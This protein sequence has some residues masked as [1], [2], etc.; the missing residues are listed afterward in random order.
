MASKVLSVIST[1]IMSNHICLH[2]FS[3]GNQQYASTSI[4]HLPVIWMHSLRPFCFSF[5]C[6]LSPFTQ[7]PHT[8]LLSLTPFLLSLLHTLIFP[9][10]KILSVTP[11]LLSLLHTLIFPTPKILSLTP[12]L[13]SLLHTPGVS[14][15]GTAHP[16]DLSRGP[17]C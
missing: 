10:P 12:S 6:S 2:I 13:L 8:Y 7:L 11:S 1:S 17:H 14:S 16:A 5:T 4:F 3:V 9:T 15:A